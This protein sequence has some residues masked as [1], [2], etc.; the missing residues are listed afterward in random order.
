LVPAGIGFLVYQPGE[1]A[2]S[3]KV[4]DRVSLAGFESPT[5]EVEQKAAKARAELAAGHG[6]KE[7]TDSAPASRLRRMVSA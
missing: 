3:S 6:V 4:P 7:K 2:I 5:A 1:L